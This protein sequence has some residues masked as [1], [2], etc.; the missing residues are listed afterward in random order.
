MIRV[1]RILA[2]KVIS[3]LR[4]EEGVY[5]DLKNAINAF[6]VTNFNYLDLASNDGLV[7]SCRIMHAKANYKHLISILYSIVHR[8]REIKLSYRTAKKYN[9]N[10]SLYAH[11]EGD[12]S[13]LSDSIKLFLWKK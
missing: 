3:D 13:L 2:F 9:T 8:S 10:N 5:H 4:F 11:L 7:K 12:P 1:K 6:Q